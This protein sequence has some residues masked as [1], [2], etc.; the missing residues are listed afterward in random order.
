MNSF[1]S[2]HM[3]IQNEVIGEMNIASATRI[4]IEEVMQLNLNEDDDNKSE[5]FQEVSEIL[6][7]CGL[8]A[9]EEEKKKREEKE[10]LKNPKPRPK[11]AKS[12]EDCDID[13]NS[14]SAIWRMLDAVSMDNGFP[15]TQPGYNFYED[16]KSWINQAEKSWEQKEEVRKKCEEW[17]KNVK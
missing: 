12:P 3:Q 8:G 14:L 2:T 4:N 15:I 16:K 7:S 17:L 13:T 1:P 5:V 6:S 11:K 9:Y 10:K